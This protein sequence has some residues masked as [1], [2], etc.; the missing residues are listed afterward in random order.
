MQPFFPL[1]S[2]VA[3]VAPGKQLKQTIQTEHNIVEN[4]NWLEANQLFTNVAEDLNSGLPTNKS[5]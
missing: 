2:V 5:R 3:I 4:P 1:S